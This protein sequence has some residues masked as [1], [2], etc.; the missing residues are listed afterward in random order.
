MEW[1]AT[2]QTAPVLSDRMIRGLTVQTVIDVML[3]AALSFKSRNLLGVRRGQERITDMQ[4]VL[5]TQERS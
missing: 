2:L 1:T 4:F 5:P 3:P